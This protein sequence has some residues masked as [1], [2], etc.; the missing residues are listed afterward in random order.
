MNKKL[1]ISTFAVLL[2]A[3][4]A[5]AQMRWAATAGVTGNNLVFKQDLVNVSPTIGYQAGVMGEIIFPGIGIG[6]D[7]GLYYNLSLIHI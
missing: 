6:L 7:L 5:S 1:I 4:S 3:L 2:C